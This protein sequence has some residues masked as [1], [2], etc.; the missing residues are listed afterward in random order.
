MV[1]LT[2]LKAL[3]WQTMLESLFDGIAQNS[4]SQINTSPYFFKGASAV[5][6]NVRGKGTTGR[7]KARGV[8]FDIFQKK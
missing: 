3:S 4:L 1:Y 6:S 8:D 2:K 5:C 7:S